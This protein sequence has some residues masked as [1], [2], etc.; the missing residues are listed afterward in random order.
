MQ[1]DLVIVGAT[2]AALGLAKTVQSNLKTLI[3]NSTEMVAYE[4]VNSYKLPGMYARGAMYSKEFRELDADILLGTEIVGTT[5]RENGGYVLELLG[6]GGFRTV[7]TGFVVDT[8]TGHEGGLSGKSLNALIIQQGGEPVPQLDWSGT[9]LLEEEH[10]E[11]YTTA[12]LK[13]DCALDWTVA[14]ARH[15]LVDHWLRR[16]H[17][18]ESWRMAAIAFCFEEQ[19]TEGSRVKVEGYHILP[20]A[21]YAEPEKSVNAGIQ[22]GRSLVS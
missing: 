21:Y 5:K 14:E 8:T 1:Y 19:V 13:F 15:Q 18:L 7:E 12:I 20:S 2:T 16:P 6:V 3:V 9:V 4:F 11:L 22:L 10:K 17:V